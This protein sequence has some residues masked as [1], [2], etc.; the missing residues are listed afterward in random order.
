LYIV[1][2]CNSLEELVFDNI[3][4]GDNYHTYARGHVGTLDTTL[5]EG[6]IKLQHPQIKLNLQ[7]LPEFR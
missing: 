4:T 2:K 7:L 5:I 3:N 6:L 1:Q